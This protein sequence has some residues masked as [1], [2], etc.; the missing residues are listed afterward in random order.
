MEW[1]FIPPPAPSAVK[2]PATI[3]SSS[4]QWTTRPTPGSIFDISPSLN[5][6]EPSSFD[7][8][9]FFRSLLASAVLQYSST[10]MAMPLEVGK[11]LLQIQ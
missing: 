10:A 9:R 6:G 8:S 4:H 11:L 1:T 3:P 2:D 7:A 5:F